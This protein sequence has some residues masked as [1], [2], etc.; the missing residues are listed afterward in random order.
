MD[1][2]GKWWWLML[3]SGGMRMVLAVAGMA[4]VAG[5]GTAASAVAAAAPGAYAF[6]YNPWGEL[7]DG[8]RAEQVLPVP[9]SG[10]PGTVR[11]LSAGA[12]TSAALLSDGTVWTW[13]DNTFGALG[14]G[15][16]GGSVSTPQR[17]AGLSGIT[18]IAVGTGD[19]DIYAVRSDGS[20]WA[21]G[22]NGAGELGNGTTVSHF[23]PIQVPGLTG[24]SQMSA[25]PDYALALRSDG[26]VRAWGN[27]S[28][29]YLG[30]GTT[31]SRLAPVQVRG[32]TGISQVSA[33]GASF[34]VRSDG[35][36]FAWGLNADGVLGMQ[37]GFFVTPAAVPGLSGVRKVASNGTAILAVVGIGGRVWAWGD[38]THGVLGDG[39]TTSRLNPEPLGLSGITQVAVSIGWNSAAVLSDGTLWTWG[40]N[41]DGELGIGNDSTLWIPVP[42][43][44]TALAAVSQVSVGVRDVL[45]IGSP[46]FAFV[47]DLSGDTTARATQALQAAG[48]VLGTVRSVVDN[49]CNDI[50]TVM[51]QN[52]VAGTRVSLGSPVSIT[53]GTRPPRPCP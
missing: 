32:L 29:G 17:V 14:N 42:V 10:L 50:G 31:T 23:N 34:A 39:S 3:R 9:V 4:V 19:R 13:G 45:A 48:L 6:G 25:G 28:N 7:G 11:Q 2:G 26:T 38:N 27:N 16:S 53:I 12:A 49:S 33:S 44:V 40:D 21:W 1:A 41:S 8:T 43:Q 20:L 15:T 37:G 51:S 22:D 36:L 35:T 30:D 46:T 18:Q 5:A 52:P 47:P 24:I